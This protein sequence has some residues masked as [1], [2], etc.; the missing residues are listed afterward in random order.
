MNELAYVNGVFGPIAE[1]RISVEDRGFQFGD[2]VYEVIVAYDGRP[3]LL[4]E[5]LARLRRSLEGIR[6]NY[7][8]A[9][10][11]LE[12]IIAEGLRCTGLPE[13]MVYIQVTRGVAPRAHLVPEGVDPTVVMTF[14][15][16]PKVSDELRR[17]GASVMTTLDTRWAKCSIK[18]VTLLPNVL[19]KSEAA[20]GGYDDAVF[21]TETG[22]VRECTA[23]NVFLVKDGRLQFPPRDE[24]VLHG[25]TQGFILECASALGIPVNE[26]SFTVD[27]LHQADEAFIS[28]TTVEVLGIA[29]LDDRP[30]GN[31]Q[32]GPITR[33]LFEEFWR[34]VRCGHTAA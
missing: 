17:R 1:A 19:A 24:S 34:R 21:V 18:A 10:N 16:L 9:A 3:F 27:A 20:A 23:A 13:A 14:K 8:F 6:L 29:S 33:R 30:V 22:E 25:I 31:G 4:E 12:P 11:P 15:P 28:G 26:R 7:D 5:H 2:G 32:V